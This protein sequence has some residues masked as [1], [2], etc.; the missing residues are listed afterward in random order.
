MSLREVFTS[1]ILYVGEALHLIFH[2][3]PVCGRREVVPLVGDLRFVGGSLPEP[4]RFFGV[5][6]CFGGFGLSGR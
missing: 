5:S 1:P 3:P 6:A 2:N 4:G